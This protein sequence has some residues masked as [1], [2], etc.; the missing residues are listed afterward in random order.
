MAIN[1][2]YRIEQALSKLR[3]AKKIGKRG[4][5]LEHDD[6][7]NSFDDMSEL[8][9]QAEELLAPLYVITSVPSVI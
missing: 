1:Q 2:K 3:E 6:K 4:E 7:G 5:W 9:N 8:V